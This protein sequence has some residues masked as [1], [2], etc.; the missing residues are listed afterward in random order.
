MGGL[1]GSQSESNGTSDKPL[2]GVSIQ[3]SANGVPTALVYGTS[4]VTPNLLWYGD[5]KAT[6][7]ESGSGGKGGG[8]SATTTTYTY[9]ASFMLGLCEGVAVDVPRVWINKS[10]KESRKKFTVFLGEEAQAPWSHLS[11]KHPTEALGYSGIVYAAAANYNLG[12]SAD[13]PNHNFEVSGRCV[14]GGDLVDANPESIVTDLHTDPR[15]GVPNAPALGDLSAY[16]TYCLASDLLV[17]P[18]YDTQTQASAMLTELVQ[19]TNTGLYY[20]EEQLKLV[21][22]GDAEVTGNGVT[23]TPDL[24]PVANLGEDDFIPAEGEDPISIQR[25]AIS[26]SEGSGAE[27]YNQVTVEYL[28]RENA[29]QVETVIVQDLADIDR[30]GLRPMPTVTAHLIAR[31]DVAQAVADLLL[32]RSVYVRA[33][34]TFKLGW[35]WCALEPTD[36][37]TLTDEL[38]GLSLCPVRILSIEED[39]Y[40]TLT[41]QAE[42]APAGVSSHVVQPVPTGGGYSVDYNATPGPVSAVCLFEPPFALANGSGLEVWAALSGPSGDALWGGANVWVSHDG[43][44]Y[45]QITTLNGASRLGVLT[46]ALQETTPDTLGVQLTG[47]GGQ[48]LSASAEAASALGTVFYVGG[49]NP[50]FMTYKGATL[51]GANA[52]T[53]D[54]LSRGLYGSTCADHLIGDPFVRLDEVL[55]KS[56]SLDLSLIGKTLYFK[57]QSFN[58]WGAGLEDLAD[59]PE[60]AYVVSGQ[61]VTGNPVSGL[62]ATA[63]TGSAVLTHL[64]WQASDGAVRYVIDQSGDGVTWLRTGET[65]DTTW[66]DSSL[67]GAA[68]RYRVAAVR[69]LA[70]SWS[71]SAF[72]NISFVGMWSANADTP[73]WRSNESTPMWSS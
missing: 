10:E 52:Y 5:F 64:E 18:V 35:R 34:Y 31:G 6:A 25:N 19:I 11:N 41:V 60:F 26:T 7:H 16:A 48:L 50:E 14:I 67:F 38:S 46:S 2:T 53:L 49:A 62:V 65:T 44:S 69:A 22:Y 27:A 17:S 24:T 72:L 3:S 9:K 39:E 45:Q 54:T 28:N 20:S 63:V 15:V 23:F 68:T 37:V 8:D 43:D 30:N 57:F 47:L 29:Y 59:L 71:S 55:A 73:M 61:Q 36:L 21:P 58:I 56:G 13:L 4:R 42:D 32:Q 51:T 40:G 12:T 66:T 70:G 33:Q 1:F